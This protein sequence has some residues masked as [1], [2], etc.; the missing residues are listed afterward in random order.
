[1][2][3]KE[4]KNPTEKKETKVKSDKPSIFARIGAWFKSLKSEWKKISWAS[5]DSV[6]KNSIIVI[7]CVV[8]V[9]AVLGLLDFILSQSIGGLSTLVQ[10]LF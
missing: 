5:F 4:T 2:A 8:I 10:R 7:V 1:M 3:E 9:A 6:R